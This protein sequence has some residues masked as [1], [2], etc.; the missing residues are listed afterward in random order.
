MTTRRTADLL[1]VAIGGG[2][3]ALTL[4]F[5]WSPLVGGPDLI[6]RQTVCWSRLLFGILCPGC[7]LT[8][9]FVALA[10]GSLADAW[11]LNR[12]GPLLFGSIV[13]LVVLHGLRFA[14]FNLRRLGVFDMVL[15]ATLAAALL[16]HSLAF[17]FT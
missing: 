9:S 1:V 15:A 13:T 17:Y 8:R 5:A 14:G 6:P 11:R 16:A 3:I 4:L 2:I 7:G 10:E 12:M